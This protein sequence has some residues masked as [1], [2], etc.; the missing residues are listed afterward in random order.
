MRIKGGVVKFL[1]GLI[2]IIAAFPGFRKARGSAWEMDLRAARDGRPTALIVKVG[3]ADVPA[4][5]IRNVGWALPTNFFD[6]FDHLVRRTHPTEDF[7]DQ[8]VERLSSPVLGY[9][10]AES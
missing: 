6:Y 1:D 7:S 5:A 2:G 3:R 10:Q 8:V 9:L 4:A